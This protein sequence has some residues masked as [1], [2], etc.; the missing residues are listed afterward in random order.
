MK[1]LLIL[2]ISV[3]CGIL[4]YAQTSVFSYGE[5]ETIKTKSAFLDPIDTNP[6]KTASCPLIKEVSLSVSS[7]KYSVKLKGYEGWENEPGDYHVIEI[8]CNGRSVFEMRY[9][10][11]WNYF[12]LAK[13]YIK[14]PN[15]PFKE[16]NLSSDCKALVFT[17]ITIGSQPPF[18]TIVIL[19][20]GKATLVYNKE[21]Y[22]N[23]METIGNV[24]K[25][26]LQLNT[27]EYHDDNI[28]YNEAEV[29]E[30]EIKNG[31]IYYTDK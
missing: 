3:V 19:R 23:D 16:F 13:D 8:L 26:K 27:V 10:D 18:T 14:S 6:N 4:S 2:T 28:P 17:G 15:T 29:A 11:G 21:G 22:I 25:L 1:R 7:F 30:L 24:V 31:M 5:D 20:N 9:D 12:Y